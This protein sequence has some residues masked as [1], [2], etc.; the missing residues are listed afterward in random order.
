MAEN[1]P[2]L[3]ESA[4]FSGADPANPATVKKDMYRTSFRGG[5]IF[6]TDRPRRNVMHFNTEHP[7][8]YFGA[9]L[10]LNAI[11][12]AEIEHDAHIEVTATYSGGVHRLTARATRDDQVGHAPT[13]TASDGS[14]GLIVNWENNAAVRATARMLISEALHDA[15][16]VDVDATILHTLQAAL[17]SQ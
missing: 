2:I 5:R 16:C 17:N 15:T 14:R 1:L 11:T 8:T 13:R 7:P 9:G 3:T 6:R 12:K 10:V 4:R